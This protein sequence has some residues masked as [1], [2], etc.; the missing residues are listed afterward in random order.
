MATK[1]VHSISD[2]V[3]RTDEDVPWLYTLSILVYNGS[4]AQ[5]K[6]I[7]TATDTA[8]LLSFLDKWITRYPGQYAGRHQITHVPFVSE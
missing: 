6:I 1:T 3:T 8:S 5:Q 7:A 2:S 4:F